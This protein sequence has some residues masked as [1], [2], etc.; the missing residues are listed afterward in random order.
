MRVHMCALEKKHIFYVNRQKHVPVLLF[1]KL[2]KMFVG[3]FDPEK[4]F[5]NNEHK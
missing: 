2:N 4:V 1:S 3:Y 5:C